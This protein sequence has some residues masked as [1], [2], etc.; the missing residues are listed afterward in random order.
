MIETCDDWCMT[1]VK[2][3]VIHDELERYV[4]SFSIKDKRE[5]VIPTLT[6]V[7][8]LVPS[9]IFVKKK[10]VIETATS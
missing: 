7:V 3:L 2:T 9:K 6:R 4:T 10:L 5:F 1:K 8:A